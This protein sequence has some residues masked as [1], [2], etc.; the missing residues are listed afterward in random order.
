MVSG[1]GHKGPPAESSALFIIITLSS[2]FH[3][4]IFD[5]NNNMKLFSV[6]ALLVAT[7]A[8][9]TIT[10]NNK[11]KQKV[12]HL[13]KNWPK[14]LDEFFRNPAAAGHAKR[15]FGACRFANKMESNMSY[16]H[17]KMV[18]TWHRCGR[19]SMDPDF[20]RM[21]DER[22]NTQD[23]FKGMTGLTNQYKKWIEAQIHVGCEN[24]AESERYVSI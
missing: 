14:M 23:P 2:Q 17:D 21:D 22:F 15:P 5:K 7:D 12:A 6:F 4:I 13:K 3:Q 9:E 18:D 20:L 11:E 19:A 1:C 8:Q 10:I 16:W 24:Q